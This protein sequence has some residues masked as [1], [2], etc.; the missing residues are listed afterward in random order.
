MAKLI[1]VI[2]K[3]IVE[4]INDL[5][6]SPLLWNRA[7][8]I[9]S[10]ISRRQS[11][12]GIGYNPAVKIPSNYWKMVVAGHYEKAL[13]PLLEDS[14]IFQTSYSWEN[15]DCASYFL[16][17]KLLKGEL[18]VVTYESNRE[19]PDRSSECRSTIRF[20]RNL[21]LDVRAA[22]RATDNYIES[23]E[24]KKRIVIDP[25]IDPNEPIECRDPYEFDSKYLAVKNWKGIADKYGMTLICDD[26]EYIIDFPDIYLSKKSLRLRISYYDAIHRFQNREFYA[27]RN[28][29]NHRLDSNLTSF[30]SILLP[31]LKYG[32]QKEHL[33]SIDLKNSQFTILAKLIGDGV[34]NDYFQ[35][36]TLNHDHIFKLSQPFQNSI[37]IPN[38]KFQSKINSIINYTCAYNSALN[39][40][41]LN[42]K[43]SETPLFTMDLEAFITLAKNGKIYEYLQIKLGLSKGKTGRAKAKKMAFEMFFSGKGI[44]GTKK[45]LIKIY[46]TVV[47][48]T[49]NYKKAH[50]NREFAILLQKTESELFI[51]CI[52]KEL[53]RLGFDTV[54]KH[55]SVLCPQSQ[56][57][58]VDKVVRDILQDKFDKYQLSIDVLAE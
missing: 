44:R 53:D 52:K 25:D 30:P 20:M 49:E 12:L 31:Y 8:K 26:G 40:Y 42:G 10:L 2:P 43:E 9:V 24:F 22:K 16:N 3:V 55:D 7:I 32:K 28:S 48:M 19:K 1:S 14:I 39:R 18:T 15:H 23:G 56:V 41:K 54:T 45:D 51:D 13:K 21:V 58:Q 11:Y 35:T 46:P 47:N 34:F 33:V 57:D 29:T 6:L 4:R 27:K 38:H 37:I 5:D 36:Y 50:G 17:P